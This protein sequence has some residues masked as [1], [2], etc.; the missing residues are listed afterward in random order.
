MIEQIINWSAVDFSGL[1]VQMFFAVTIAL[2][3]R[4]NQK[5]PVA[6][7]LMTGAALIILGLGDSFNAS[8]VSLMSIIN[9]FLWLAVG[10][11]RY[12]QKTIS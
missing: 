10:W 11:Q 6:T 5:P 8:A 4:D 7:S 3:L 9:G 2:M 12:K 1:V